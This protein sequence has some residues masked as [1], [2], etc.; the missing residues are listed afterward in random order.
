MAKDIKDSIALVKEAGIKLNI[1][2]NELDALIKAA[3][4]YEADMNAI[5]DEINSLKAKKSKVASEIESTKKAF[6]EYRE[7]EVNEIGVTRKAAESLMQQAKRDI[8]FA[9]TSR[10]DA[11][12]LKENSQKELAKATELK[13]LYEDKVSSFNQFISSSK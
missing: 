3:K 1:A 2:A 11:E 13:K 10:R 9:V 12:I 4:A 7:K 8:E 5:K 6:E